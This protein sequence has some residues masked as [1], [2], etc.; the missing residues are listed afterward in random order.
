M[1]VPRA[2]EKTVRHLM[3]KCPKCTR[4]A[5]ERFKEAMSQLP[6]PQFVTGMSTLP[7]ASATDGFGNPVAP[8]QVLPVPR[9]TFN[10]RPGVPPRYNLKGRIRAYRQVVEWLH[11]RA[12]VPEVLAAI[13]IATFSKGGTVWFCGNGGS[14]ADC[15]HLAA[16]YVNG[17]TMKGALTKPMNARALTV[18]S[19]V[20][21]AIGNDRGFEEIFLKQLQAGVRGHDTVVMHSTS[22]QSRNLIVAAEWLKLYHPRVPVVALLGSRDRCG[23]SPLALLARAAIYVETDDAQATQLGHMMLQH[24]VVEVVECSAQ[25]EWKTQKSP[26]NAVKD[27][28][29]TYG[30]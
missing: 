17:M 4:E 19:S 15:Q 24:L 5:E 10:D 29:P 28:Q 8:N 1:P 26:V 11:D 6:Q 21:T 25:H 27:P 7:P 23:L 3:G 22:G 2:R 9:P 16:E 14:A 20:L 18:D 30:N 12:H 13:Y